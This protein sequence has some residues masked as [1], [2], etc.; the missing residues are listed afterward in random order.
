MGIECNLPLV[1]MALLVLV[2]ALALLVK[3]LDQV[4]LDTRGSNKKITHHTQPNIQRSK[5]L[6]SQIQ[7]SPVH[8]ALIEPI[9]ITIIIIYSP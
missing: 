2:L 4:C 5:Q 6:A 7:H 8:K 1:Q 3:H 9:K